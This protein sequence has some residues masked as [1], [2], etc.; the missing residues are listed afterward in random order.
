MQF[1]FSTGSLW[2]YSLERCFALAKTAGYDGLELMVDQRWDSRQIGFLQGLVE[3]FELPIVAV[4]S[5]FWPSIPGWPPDQPGRITQ[6]IQIA[7]AL[8]AQTLIHHL[9]ARISTMFAVVGSRFIGVPAPWLRGEASYKQ[10]LETEYAPLQANTPVKLCIENMPAWN[11][12]GRSWR[13]HHW[14]T[15]DQMMQFGHITMDTTHLGTW[16]LEPVEIYQKWGK[17]VGHVHL[18]NYDGREHRRPG[19][20]RLKLAELLATMTQDGY[21][22]AISLEVYPEVLDAGQDDEKVIAQMQ[23]CLEFC[24]QAVT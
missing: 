3:Q 10:W 22:G 12:L 24:R 2:S 5:P 4:H 6:S 23:N 7:E 18:S 15:P 13:L 14:N 1:V 17:R 8:N 11:R 19:D 16:G 9:P 20:G 21:E